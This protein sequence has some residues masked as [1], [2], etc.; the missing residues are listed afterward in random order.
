MLKCP[1][2]IFV[3]VGRCSQNKLKATSDCIT[4]RFEAAPVIVPPEIM[5]TDSSRLLYSEC[6][7][8]F[9]H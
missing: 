4:S 3:S 8:L 1:G 6:V 2:F 7:F 5:L 9:F